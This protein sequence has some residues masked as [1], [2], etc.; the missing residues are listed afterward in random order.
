MLKKISR[1]PSSGMEMKA[2]EFIKY[3]F[4]IDDR[5]FSNPI[6]Q[7][8]YARIWNSNSKRCLTQLL[9]LG[10]HLTKR[11]SIFLSSE[12]KKAWLSPAGIPQWVEI[13]LKRLL[14]PCTCVFTKYLLSTYLLI[15]F[16]SHFGILV[17]Y[18][19]EVTDIL[20]NSFF[21]FFT[22]QGKT[23]KTEL[24]VKKITE[25]KWQ[26][27]QKRSFQNLWWARH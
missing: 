22:K 17:A 2:T 12:H 1:N 16:S 25:L 24:K 10:T 13:I 18:G 26:K 9:V 23:G 11:R 5:T 27:D 15:S 14:F 20:C 19:D 3:C 7:K 8:W 6:F 21:P 4:E